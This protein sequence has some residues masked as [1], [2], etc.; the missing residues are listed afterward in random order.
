MQVLNLIEPF[1]GS[2]IYSNGKPLAGKVLISFLMCN[3]FLQL[4]IQAQ[5]KH[6]RP[7]VAKPQ[8]QMQ[9]ALLSAKSI[10]RD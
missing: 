9:T 6:T 8:T 1:K 2:M 4:S 5:V 3:C 7:A 10:C